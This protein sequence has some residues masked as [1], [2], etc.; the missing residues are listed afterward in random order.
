[1]AKV[2]LS[3]A[4]KLTGK[5]RTTIWRH[6]HSGKL[7]IER[8][9]DGLPFVDT[10]ELIRVYGEL[11]PIA[12]DSSE[13]KPHQA[14]Y[15]YEDLIAIVDLLRKEQAEMKAEIENLT[16]RLTYIPEPNSKE[17]SPVTQ[18]KKPEDDPDWPEGVMTLADIILRNEI[19]SRYGTQ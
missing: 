11:E 12:T 14:T 16:N 9:R 5:N 19:K 2:N 17:L 8:D 1:M 15:D 4:A 10:S 3:Q 7:S 18:S 13:K 6:I